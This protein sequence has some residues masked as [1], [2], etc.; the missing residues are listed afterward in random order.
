MRNFFKALAFVA[1]LAP[2]AAF[3]AVSTTQHNLSVGGPNTNARA[4]SE[5]GICVF[6]HTPHGASQQRAIWNRA[7][8]AVNYTWGGTTQTTTGTPLP[9]TNAAFSSVT[10]KCL[11]CH[12]GSVA[13]GSVTNA[14]GGAAGVIAMGGTHLTAGVLNATAGANRVGNGADLSGNHPVGI[15]YAGQPGSSAV[16]SGKYGSVVTGGAC[17]SASNNCTSLSNEIN[18]TLVAGVRQVDCT[19]CHDV[20]GTALPH[21]LTVTNVASAI[22]LA[23]HIQ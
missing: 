9:T 12:D 20:H 7:A 15:P 5:T 8:N 23:C 13:V 22:C 6:C 21:M 1:V 2:A 11:S 16:V 4:T 14:G 19:S 3:G 17:T 18:L 10:L